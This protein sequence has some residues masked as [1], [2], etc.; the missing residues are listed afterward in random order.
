MARTPSKMISLGTAAAHFSLPD[1]RHEIVALEH[2]RGRP[3]LVMFLSN[4]CPFVKHIAREIAAL[5]KEYQAQGLRA[6]GISSNDAIAYPADAPALMREEAAIQGYAFPYLF[7]ET[8]AVARAYDAA[9]TPDFFLYDKNHR[10]VYRGQ[11]DGARPGN[12]IPVSG[13]SLREAC[14]AVLAGRALNP[15]QVPSLGCNIKWKP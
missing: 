9:C 2:A 1:T 15:I 7:D 12:E 3:L 4:H 8:Q 10:L 14:D 11:F 5:A 6:V 13:N